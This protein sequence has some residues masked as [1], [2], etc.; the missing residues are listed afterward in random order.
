MSVEERARAQ[1]AKRAARKE[2]KRRARAEAGDGP[3]EGA[4]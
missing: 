3:P 2:A 1:E 4:R